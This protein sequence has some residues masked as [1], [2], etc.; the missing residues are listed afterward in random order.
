MRLRPTDPQAARQRADGAPCRARWPWGRRAWRRACVIAGCVAAFAAAASAQVPAGVPAGGADTAAALTPRTLALTLAGRSVAVDVYRPAGT[1]R[2]AV[3]LSHGFTRSRTTLGGHAAALAGAGVLALTPDLPYT[4]DFRRNA[5]GLAE[6]VAMLRA[7]A[8]APGAA[9]AAWGGPVDRVVLVGFS[10]GALSSLLAAGTPG[11]VGY[12]GLDAFDRVER[13]A[14]DGGNTALGL[15]HARTLKTEALLL[16][17]P[18]SNCNAQA[19]SAPWG[20][21]LPALLA[22]TVIEGATHCDF[23]SPT[24]WM[25]RLACGEADPARQARV[26]AALLQA[27]R[28]WL[29]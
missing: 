25:C 24:D 26:R 7:G 6:L 9:S 15:E 2:G 11:V 17:A 10:A 5:Q 12:V 19:V 29:P 3:V 23:E 13:A 18:P 27:V 1:P 4:F 14:A 28:R 8:S 16:R 20:T 21:A 22:D